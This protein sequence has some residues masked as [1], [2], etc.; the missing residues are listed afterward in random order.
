MERVK[1][2]LA[3][4]RAITLRTEIMHRSH[5]RIKT[6]GERLLLVTSVRAIDNER[7]KTSSTMGRTN[8]ERI[9]RDLR[10]Q[11][12]LLTTGP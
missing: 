8:D 7:G 4:P 10:E 5:V 6:R 2:N 1:I 12:S 3:A 11:G 9:E